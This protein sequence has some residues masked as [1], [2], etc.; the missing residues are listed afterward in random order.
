ME[1]APSTHRGWL[2]PSCMD[3]ASGGVG[4]HPEFGMGNPGAAGKQ[5]QHPT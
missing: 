1:E 5:L 4:N 2:S 3:G